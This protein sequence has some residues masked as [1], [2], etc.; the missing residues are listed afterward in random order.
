MTAKINYEG[1]VAIVYLA[2]YLD[3]ES[4]SAFRHLCLGQLMNRKVVFDF[5]NLRFV[6]S[7][8]ISS[9][10][11][12]FR[13]YTEQSPHR[14]RFSAV[15]SEF[16]RLFMA[17]QLVWAEIFE[18]EQDAAVAFQRPDVVPAALAQGFEE[19][20]QEWEDG[21]GEE[22]P[23]PAEGGISLESPGSLEPMAAEVV[24][25]PHALESNLVTGDRKIPVV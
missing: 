18:N 2:G 16:R 7:C 21:I 19:D 23:P 13:D 12:T 24:L 8:G 6:G 25:D 3:F 15:G 5:K 14:P 17:S 11:E 22:L 1:D 20:I 9:F 4:S 10:L